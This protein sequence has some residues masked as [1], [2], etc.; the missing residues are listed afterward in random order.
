M[1]ETLNNN[2]IDVSALSWCLAE[3]NTA[4]EQAERF[5][6]QY[7][8][9]PGNA[10]L[11]R[12]AQASLHQ[13]HG[14]L[15]V[16]DI[17]GLAKITEEAERLLELFGQS[18]LDLSSASVDAIGAGF[19][20][21]VEYCENL[22]DGAAHLPVRL[23][24]YLRD[25][26]ALRSAERIHPADLFFPKL[27]VRPP[28]MPDDGMAWEEGET[29]LVR[30]QFEQGLLRYLRDSADAQGRKDML[31]AIA[32]IESA[33]RQSAGHTF[34]WVSLAFFDAMQDVS[35]AGD[36]FSKRLVARLNLQ[37]RK[38][39]EQSG[40]VADQLLIDT[41]FQIARV[42]NPSAFVAQVIEMYAIK[43]AVPNDYETPYFLR[44]NA[45]ALT[46]FKEA[47][48]SAKL[49][50]DRVTRGQ[51]DGLS[52]FDAECRNMRKQAELL[53]AP[54]MA[55][56]SD[57]ISRVVAGLT[58][59]TLSSQLSLEIA[60]SLLF[61][62][63]AMV[64]RSRIDQEYE[65]R[66][67]NMATRLAQVAGGNAPDEMPQWLAE[68]SNAA[69]ER[70][71]TQAFVGEMLLNLRG[72]EKTLDAFFRDPND[73]AELPN[74]GNQLRQTGGALSL[75][76]HTD[77]AAGTMAVAS[78]ASALVAG[79]AAD[80]LLAA[81]I[82]D[83]LSALGFFVETL[84]TPGNHSLAYEFDADTQVFRVKTVQVAK[85]VD[86]PPVPQ[87]AAMPVQIVAKPSA[88]AFITDLPIADPETLADPFPM[89]L[90][91]VIPAPV[92]L[93]EPEAFIEPA[94]DEAVVFDFASLD[95]A[96]FAEPIDTLPMAVPEIE[97]AASVVSTPVLSDVEVDAEL[98]EIFLGEAQE[99]LESIIDA[100]EKL[101]RSASDSGSLTTAR[102]GYHTLKGSGRMVGLT[103]FGDAAWGMEQTLNLCLSEQ[104]GAS[105][106][107]LAMIES[108]CVQFS[109][110]VQELT[111]EPRTK[112][113]PEF[114]VE[115]ARR[116]R[117]GE[118]LL[119]QAEV[120]VPEFASALDT[121]LEVQDIAEIDLFAELAESTEAAESVATAEPV[122]ALDALFAAP[123][124][125]QDDLLHADQ[126]LFA[127]EAALVFDDS[128]AEP[129]AFTDFGAFLVDEPLEPE[130]LELLDAESVEQSDVDDLFALDKAVAFDEPTDAPELNVDDKLNA[131]FIVAGLGAAA[132]IALALP[133]V[134]PEAQAENPLYQIFLAEADDL[135]RVLEN[136]IAAFVADSHHQA[137]E[138]AV[139]AAHS[140]GGSSLVVGLPQVS[141]IA[142]SLERWMQAQRKKGFSPSHGD[143]KV[144]QL[145][146]RRLTA[147]LHTFAAG[148]PA[149]DD[150]IAVKAAMEIAAAQEMEHPGQDLLPGGEIAEQVDIADVAFAP[151]ESDAQM[152]SD[153][154]VAHSFSDDLDP[155]LFEIF[156]MEADEYLPA[157]GTDLRKWEQA[158]SNTSV[159]QS[160]M[161]AFHTV[162]GGARMAGAMTLGQRVHEMETKVESVAHLSRAPAELVTGLIADYDHVVSLFEALKDPATAPTASVTP[163]VVVASFAAPAAASAAP[164]VAAAFVAPVATAPMGVSPQVLATPAPQ[165]HQLVRVRADLLDRMVNEAGEVSIARSRMEN[166][167]ASIK[168]SINDLTENVHRLRAQLREIEIQAETQIQAR[169]QTQ[170]TAG[171]F[172]PLEYD[173]FTRFQELTRMMAESVNDVSTVQQNLVRSLNEATADLTRQGQVTRDLQQN[174][175][176]VRMVQF[177][178]ISDRL[179][180]VVRQAAK[181]TGKRVNLDIRG[182]AAEIDRSV[183]E[184]MA[185]PL[186]HLLRNAVAHGVERPD[187]RAIAGKSE[188]GEISVEVRQEGNEVV[189]TLADDGAGL[190]FDKIRQRAISNGLLA[191][192]AVATDSELADLIFMPGFSTATEVTTLAGRGVG[193]DVVRSEVAAL[194]GRIE[195]LSEAQKGSRFVVHL[196]LTLAVTQVV[197]VTVGEHKYALPSVLVEQVMQLKPDALASLYEQKT[198]E[199]H[200]QRVQA[201]YLGSLLEIPDTTP[202]VQRYSPIIVLRSGSHH[203]AIHV[204]SIIGNQEVVVKN[205]GP[206]LSRLHGVAGATVLGNGEI[207]LILN[208]VQIFSA[209]GYQAL[210]IEKVKAQ[211]ASQQGGS[212]AVVPDFN[213]DLPPTVM[214]VDD[215]LTVR[216][217]SQRFLSRENY[218][219]VLAKDGVDALKQLQDV[220][221]DVMLVDIE[222]PRMDGFDL[223]R[224]IRGDARLKHI[225]IIMITSRTADKHRNHA[226]SLG[227]NVFLGKP[228]SE[229][230]LIAHVKQL[231]AAARK[232]KTH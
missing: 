37:V 132:S 3:I 62:E 70:Q 194:G 180:R 29:K 54:G 163:Q 50:W 177:G 39:L 160:L 164:V 144:L 133:A 35:I 184:R 68:L 43:G 143:K 228:F 38:S 27:S 191:Q 127:D 66:A 75:L 128:P 135:S 159:A 179:Y 104:K 33:E 167:V 109:Q 153:D 225:P 231:T 73:A 148:Q 230:D 113:A 56:L 137:I 155:E 126:A 154:L 69:Q 232:D 201:E 10:G 1:N 142:Y 226:L 36:V 41:L 195:T 178:S 98:M 61:V 123:V 206:Q 112:I 229:E 17:T 204:D 4:L 102:R 19:T 193:M 44:Q 198:L 24:P 215:S 212:T 18:Q 124:E 20:A 176:R 147:M 196:P 88:G 149:E 67:L 183:L 222:M 111:L 51:F 78:A 175:M 45:G 76:G 217:V 105:P 181:E 157:I 57:A 186:E 59:K 168:G 58:E 134:Q 139:R 227:V 211:E 141:T 16:V 64:K 97:V 152:M 11:L 187:T 46:Q 218:H 169:T 216:K 114:I 145:L 129:G 34:W 150:T 87:V 162:K 9:E 118:P 63:E 86:L 83:S 213:F 200:G 47:L 28:R 107:L 99:V 119:A 151:V 182:T 214:V 48:G 52:E 6:R 30:G 158:P 110:W 5:L 223:T 209:A 171:N 103:D 203:A 189:L 91:G 116:L 74:I 146:V 185:G 165:A 42:S 22:V 172:D 77:A 174:L 140:L 205:V 13:A 100:H 65:S 192:D 208:P 170:T 173:R 95:E 21:L 94:L 14:A 53:K 161:R 32:R 15:A 210:R 72:A 136:E 138:P 7:L 121:S 101:L 40:K 224:N 26:Q 122:D 220:L 219:V 106:A 79:Q 130:A 115:N 190:N 31:E 12:S 108:T 49:A 8:A 23:F 96:A 25:M 71:S 207:V 93:A 84:A 81:N 125:V 166:E 55:K 199:W 60:T 80:E 89:Y 90:V 92:A 156:V 117:D 131:G 197:L 82:A 2:Q 120:A 85:R 202:L 221:P 188:T